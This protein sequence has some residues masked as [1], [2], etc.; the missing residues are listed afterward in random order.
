MILLF[1]MSGDARFAARRCRS[2]LD[3]DA[4]RSGAGRPL[5]RRACLAR[6]LDE[7]FRR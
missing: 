6:R 1:V 2:G 5:A 7:G 3:D 4:V